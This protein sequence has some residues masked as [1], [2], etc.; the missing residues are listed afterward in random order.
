MRPYGDTTPVP[1]IRKARA[2]VMFSRA[3]RNTACGSWP[4]HP[5]VTLH[6][7]PTSA[8]GRTAPKPR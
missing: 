7:T 2:L 5:L 8:S 4:P 1:L 6:S 3:D